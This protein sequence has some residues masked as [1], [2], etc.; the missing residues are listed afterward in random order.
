MTVVS[1][2]AKENVKEM[3]KRPEKKQEI[4][5]ALSSFYIL[6]FGLWGSLNFMLLLSF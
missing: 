5:F 1:S 4:G 6:L 3:F 2:E